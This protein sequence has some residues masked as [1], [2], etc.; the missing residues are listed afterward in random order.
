MPDTS[1]APFASVLVAT[2]DSATRELLRERLRGSRVSHCDNGLDLIRLTLSSAPELVILDLDLPLLGGFPCIRLLKDD[3]FPRHPLIIALGDGAK[4]A[5]QFWA[6]SCGADQVLSRPVDLLEL[7][8]SLRG[9]NPPPLPRSSVFTA[10]APRLSRQEV[11]HFAA[12]TSERRLFRV[13]MGHELAVMDVSTQSLEHVVETVAR[14]LASLF[15]FQSLAVL[16]HV[17]GEGELLF[18]VGAEMSESAV[19]DFEALL[20]AK[21][22]EHYMVRASALRTM[23]RTLLGQPF[24]VRQG[25]SLQPVHLHPARTEETYCLL[26]LSGIAAD[27]LPREAMATL[28]LLLDSAQLVLERKYF[29]DLAQRRGVIQA[30]EEERGRG[31]FLALL[32]KEME[33]ARREGT[34]LALFTIEVARFDN[35]PRPLNEAEQQGFVSFLERTILNGMGPPHLVARVGALLYAFVFVRTPLER[36][37]KSQNQI[38]Q[39]LV[40]SAQQYLPLSGAET[41]FAMGLAMFDPDR[42]RQPEAFLELA[43]PI[44]TA[45]DGGAAD[46][47]II[48]F[49]GR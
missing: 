19:S 35:L 48:G 14:T 18:H 22:K 15:D 46:D 24:P 11:H 1:L 16:F 10:Y 26:A 37:A 20:L 45:E 47:K 9:L 3:R 29:M 44:V 12:D 39:N 28:T 23:P 4:P 40:R 21:L 43:R 30:L 32:G 42:V 17:E 27:A 8:E 2:T 33:L 25:A 49:R 38:R 13:E 41:R 34:P 31:F 36:A 5:D 7:Q 6:L